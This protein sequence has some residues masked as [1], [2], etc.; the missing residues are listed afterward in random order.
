MEGKG[1]GLRMAGKV[2]LSDALPVNGAGDG[3]AQLHLLTGAALGVVSQIE[4]GGGGIVPAF[5]VAGIPQRIGSGQINIHQ[6]DVAAV[7]RKNQIIAFGNEGQG[8]GIGRQG[9]VL[10]PVLPGHQS[11]ILLAAGENE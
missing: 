4:H 11:P 5:I 10:P 8:N 1:S 7:K 3:L 6:R 9:G 2:H